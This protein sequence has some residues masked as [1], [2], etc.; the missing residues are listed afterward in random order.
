M[1]KWTLQNHSRGQAQTVPPLITCAKRQKG[2]WLENAFD[3]RFG[4]GYLMF[5]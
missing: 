2:Y 5:P 3:R 1:T 4:D